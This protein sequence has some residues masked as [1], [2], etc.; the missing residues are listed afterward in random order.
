MVYFRVTEDEFKKLNQICTS[1]GARSLSDL[2]RHAIEKILQNSGDGAEGNQ[3]QMEL[4]RRIDRLTKMIENLEAR[5]T[6]P[7]AKGA[8]GGA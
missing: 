4:L 7:T 3:V 5:L 2:A 6:S 8:G 1:S